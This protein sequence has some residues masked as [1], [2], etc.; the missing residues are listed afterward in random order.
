MAHFALLPFGSAGDVLPFIWLGRHLK[1]RGHRVTL[2]PA[3]LFA[4]A[5]RAASLDVIPLGTPEE[6]ERLTT[7]PRLWRLYQGT[8]LVFETAGQGAADYFHA[9]EALAAAG[10]RPDVLLAPCTT[11]GARIAREKLGIPLITVHLQPA[12]LISA[13]DLP[14][15]VPGMHH[16]RRLPLWLR[17]RLV[18]IRNPA[19]AFAAP[20]VAQTCR[21]LGVK[22]PR[23]LWWDWANSPD[24]VLA[25]FPEW[26]AAPQPDW[27]PNLLQWDFPLE[28]LTTERS[29]PPGLARFLAEGDQPIVF[30]P[31]SA[32][33]Q[34]QRFFQTAL[35]TVWRLGC[36]AVFVSSKPEQLP[37]DL[38]PTV[39]AID[40]VPF[41]AVLPQSA[42]FVHHGGI[43][44][45]SQ[46]FA[47]G[48]PQLLMAMAHDQPDNAHRLE[49][50]HAGI[51]L[52]PRS[53]KPKQ[54][55]RALRHLL[56]DSA[57]ASACQAIR[58]RLQL[59]RPTEDLVTWIEARL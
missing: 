14:V 27:P 3:C 13:Y 25:L 1:T 32:N 19:D 9:I 50:L 39:F 8:K 59:R 36:R 31:G 49:Q 46:G 2:V 58:T 29:L 43:G 18:K 57:V 26:F 48:V 44:T 22:P 7:D 56:A 47:A 38:P 11:F 17:R 30:T 53:F 12:A 51:G 55:V 24:G 35:E 10:S 15:L 41:S 5:G 54:V 33:V 40:Y 6:F 21:Q 52:T 23:S 16:L 20:S 37:P 28:D 45:L 34:A 4:E 42:A